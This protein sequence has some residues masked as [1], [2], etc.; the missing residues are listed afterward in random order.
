[1]RRMRGGSGGHLYIYFG[2]EGGL[3]LYAQSDAIERTGLRTVGLF[4]M[5][6]SRGDV[7]IGVVV[8][9]EC[10]AGYFWYGKDEPLDLTAVGHVVDERVAVPAGRP[11]AIGRV[12]GHAVWAAARW[13]A[14]THDNFRVADLSLS[15]S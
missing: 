9:A 11:D 3:A 12:H 1:M 15:M 4:D 6:A 5:A 8:A 10:G 7:Q 2:A 14:L 13:R